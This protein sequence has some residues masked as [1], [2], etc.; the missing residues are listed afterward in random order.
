MLG[1]PEAEF[2]KMA[3]PSDVSIRPNCNHQ[4]DLR[5]SPIGCEGSLNQGSRASPKVRPHPLPG[6][7][8]KVGA[9]GEI[10]DAA[11]VFL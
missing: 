3:G 11:R 2:D 9:D 6:N 10:C 5:T 4:E 1:E 7:D 8:G